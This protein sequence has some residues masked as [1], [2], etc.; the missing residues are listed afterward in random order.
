MSKIYDMDFLASYMYNLFLFA[1]QM[2]YPVF[3]LYNK[4]NTS[5]I[6]SKKWGKQ[7]E[8]RRR[9]Q[10]FRKFS[11]KTRLV[12]TLLLISIIPLAGISGYSFHIFS[13]A[14]REKLS[15]SISQTLSMI[16][17]NMVNE[18]E[19]YQYLCGSICISQEIKEGL[20]KKDMTDMEKNQAITE[21]Q[22]M[23]RSKIIY[24]AQAKNITVYDTDGNIFYDLGYDGF[25]PEDV[26]MILTRL[27]NEDQ[28]V[29]AYT[30]T[31]RDRDILVLGRRIYEQYSQSRVIG[32]TLISIDE[33]I[34]S[35]TVLEPVGLADSSNIM[36]MNMDGM[37]LSSWDR[38]VSLGQTVDPELLENIQEKLPAR[39]ASF[40]IHKDGEEQL[41][42]YIFNK[43]LNQLFVYT[44][45]YHYINSEVYVMLRKILIVAFLLVVLC[46][47]IVAMVY[48][49]ITS[50]IRSMLDF[51]KELSRGNLSVRIF[52][53]HKDELSDLS[54]SMNHMA[55]T[56]RHL[57]EQQKDQEKKK[58]E[59]E[60]QM[61]QYQLNPH[62]LFNTLNSLRFVAAMHKDQ[63]VS[64]GIQA[65]SSLLQNTLTNKNEYITIKEELENLQNYFSILRIRYAGSF[66]YSFHVE[67]DEL[68][69]CLVPKLILQPLAENSVM[70][71]SSDDGS[72]M[73][74]QITLWEE[75][76][77]IVIELNDDGKG[78]EVTQE[79][80]APHKE[81]RKIGISNVNDRIQLNFGR[82]YGLHIDS[83]PGE[84]TTCTL[85][86]PRLEHV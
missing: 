50:P 25:Y 14:L 11:I 37:V 17:L 47:G 55:D 63:I 71:G 79:S 13:V 62:F 68:L 23:I 1:F 10:G 82:E 21:I 26:D 34:F 38:N 72:V 41:V 40:S 75:N 15:A 45:P 46:I 48:L 76:G 19:K 33:K 83:H 81:R 65:L 9:Y 28:D 59:M 29:W 57:M 64:D 7:M 2:D 35:K 78:F 43:N 20:L 85:T 3:F 60:L 16:N 54:K 70:H 69:T 51:C 18:V 61:L 22:K 30:H 66:E 27:K 4:R 39:K 80:L 52:D 73:E 84:G 49:G 5:G 74:I 6:R 42:T 36:Y 86:L 32:Y 8:K 67:D 31:Y 77:H 56:I 53:E 24:P 44:M 58:R 12:I